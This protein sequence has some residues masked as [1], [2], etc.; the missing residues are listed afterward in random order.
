MS[1]LFQRLNGGF[2]PV[3]IS[4]VHSFD[5]ALTAEFVFPFG[6]VKLSA[7]LWGSTAY[8]LLQDVSL[9][10]EVLK[11]HDELL[12]V[13]KTLRKSNAPVIERLEYIGEDQNVE[14][15]NG[16]ETFYMSGPATKSQS[17]YDLPLS[18]R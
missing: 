4:K 13:M 1:I 15:I 14:A 8:I 12:C 6:R 7:V 18:A 11:V 5:H 3:H 17:P 2:M 9:K 16:P 10:A